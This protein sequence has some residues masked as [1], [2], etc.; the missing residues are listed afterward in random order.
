LSDL[1]IAPSVG[2]IARRMWQVDAVP[3]RAAGRTGLPMSGART[4]LL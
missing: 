3:A 1:G 4:A 2:I